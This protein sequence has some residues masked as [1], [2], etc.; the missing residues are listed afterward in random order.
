MIVRDGSRGG[1]SCSASGVRPSRTPATSSAIAGMPD[2]LDVRSSDPDILASSFSICRAASLTS[3]R[4]ACGSTTMTPFD[5]AGEDRLHAPAVARLLAEPPAHFLH[6]VVQ[7]PRD[8]P[9][10][11]V[12]EVESWRRQVARAVACGDSRD[13]HGRAGR[14]APRGSTP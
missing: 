5:H 9:E 11:V 4:R 7:R 8:R 14:C 12:A 10:L 3:C 2:G 1:D 13:E 6:R